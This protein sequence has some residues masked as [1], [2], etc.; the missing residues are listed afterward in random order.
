MNKR[1]W[2]V[3]SRSSMNLTLE[4]DKVQGSNEFDGNDDHREISA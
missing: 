1:V 4:V 3:Y 2:V